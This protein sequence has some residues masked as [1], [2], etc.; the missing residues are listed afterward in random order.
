MGS[1]QDADLIGYGERIEQAEHATH[2]AGSAR[3]R[4][5]G[6]ERGDRVGHQTGVVDE[7]ERGQGE[8]LFVY[9]AW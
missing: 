2:D 4:A 1:A 7:R 5:G 3:R 9:R 6:G 8:R